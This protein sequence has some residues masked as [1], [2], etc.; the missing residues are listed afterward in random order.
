M[1]KETIRRHTTNDKKRQTRCINFDPFGFDIPERFEELQ[2]QETK[3]E[4]VI[5][6]LKGNQASKNHYDPNY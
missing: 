6:L 4:V 3:L 1:T 2:I 5:K